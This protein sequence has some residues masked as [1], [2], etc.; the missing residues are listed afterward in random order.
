MKS[1]ITGNWSGARPE[2]LDSARDAARRAGVSVGTWIDSVIHD[3]SQQQSRGYAARSDAAAFESLTTRLDEL[4]ARLDRL[5]LP[6]VPDPQLSQTPSASDIEQAVAEIA[7][8]QRMLDSEFVEAP[9]SSGIESPGLERQ[10]RLITEKI[11]ALRRPCGVEDAVGALRAELTTIYRT[12]A[13]VAPRS[14]LVSLEAEMRALSDRI[15]A[16]RYAGVDASTAAGLERGIDD[17]REALKTLRPAESLGGVQELVK[18]LALKIDGLASGGGDET[19]LRHIELAISKLRDV[20]AVAASGEALAALSAEVAGISAKVE[21][22]LAARQDDGLGALSG[23]IEAL[24]K[25]LEQRESAPGWHSDDLEAQIARLIEKIDAS[26][27]RLQH[28]DAIERT[29]E[30]LTVQIGEVRVSAVEAAE[31]A[32]RAVVREMGS[33]GSSSAETFA[34][35]RDLSELRIVQSASDNQTQAALEA[36]HRTLEKLVERIATLES[37]LRDDSGALAPT[38]SRSVAGGS[39]AVS[40]PKSPAR[41]T[42]E[43]RPIDPTLPADTPL[44]PGSVSPRGRVSAAERIGASEAAPQVQ[45]NGMPEAGNRTN[46]IA[47]AR[48]AAQAAQAESASLAHAKASERDRRYQAPGEAKPAG[49]RLALAAAIIL[50]AVGTMYFA[51]TLFNG[52]DGWRAE[53]Q[54][55]ISP[56]ITRG[57][58]ESTPGPSIRREDGDFLVPPADPNEPRPSERQ[59]SAPPPAI[60]ALPPSGVTEP[61]REIRPAPGLAPRGNAPDFTGSILPV[62]PQ[63]SDPSRSPPQVNAVQG[64]STAD[65]LPVSI[66]SQT[67]RDAAVGGD[68]A[69]EYE[70]GARYAEGRGVAQNLEEAVRWLERAANQGLAPAQYRLGSHYEKGQGT[71]KDVQMAR[72]LYTA[73]SEKGHAKAMH[74]L[75]VLYAEGIEGKPDYRLAAQWFRRAA[76]HGIADSQYNL[77]ILYARGIGVE[78]NLAESYKWFAL[79]AKQGDQDAGRKRDDVAQRIDP[80]S[81][82]AARLAVQTWTAQPQPEAAIIV[83]APGGG[84]DR[85]NASPAKGRPGASGSRKTGTT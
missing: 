85:P 22:L 62:P 59:G 24:M 65:R 70:I 23:R 51:A 12:L 16:S 80:Q 33:G 69:A 81:L 57:E 67:L 6:R 53:L 47:A 2:A 71:K 10:L 20:A 32:A 15:G 76:E 48:R 21:R 41:A 8:R 31:R 28:L 74:N 17:I 84:H 30:T 34:L 64:S 37:E 60:T 27:A 68:P 4:A 42:R 26:G 46:F 83:R 45:L 58:G 66:G 29:L 18:T 54:E 78:Q 14:A 77:G 73:A 55:R 19:A 13:D 35:R 56:A 50:M 36:V 75:A 49:R 5:S 63:D 38:S 43:P 44:E 72:R 40:A 11:E 79:A 3:V 7:A 61:S 25:R 39:T 1:G 9:S 52:G 82:V